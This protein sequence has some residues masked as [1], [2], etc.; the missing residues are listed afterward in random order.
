ME[1][2]CAVMNVQIINLATMDN[3]LEFSLE[4]HSI[5]V[6]VLWDI[7]IILIIGQPVLAEILHRIT[8]LKIGQI[9]WTLHQVK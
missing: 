6:T 1:Q 4:V 5:A 7:T 3:R 8:L 9:V 2:Q